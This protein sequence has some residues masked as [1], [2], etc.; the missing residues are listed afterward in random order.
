MKKMC[1][2]ADRY[3]VYVTDKACKGCGSSG[4][5]CD[6]C[7]DCHE[8][9]C[10]AKQNDLLRKQLEAVENL[11]RLQLGMIQLRCNYCGK[12]RDYEWDPVC[13]DCKPKSP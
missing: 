3:A 12:Q 1:Q 10:L 13:M 2:C 8:N 6:S 9:D 5:M 7:L 11:Y 4:V